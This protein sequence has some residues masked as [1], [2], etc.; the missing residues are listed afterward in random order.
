MNRR[1]SLAFHLNKKMG[2][3]IRRN[4]TTRG[5]PH[6]SKESRLME[7]TTMGYLFNSRRDLFILQGKSFIVRVIEGKCMN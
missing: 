6:N 3:E 5:S 1:Q 7:G 4:T 2:A